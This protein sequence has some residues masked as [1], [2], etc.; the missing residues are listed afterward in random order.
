MWRCVRLTALR[1]LVQLRVFRF[2]SQPLIKYISTKLFAN[3]SPPKRFVL[4]F[5]F[6]EQRLC[7][8][9][10]YKTV[11]IITFNKQWIVFIRAPCDQLLVMTDRFCSEHVS[12]AVEPCINPAVG[13]IAASRSNELQKLTSH[14]EKLNITWVNKRVVLELH[15]TAGKCSAETIMYRNP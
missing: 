2:W 13:F 9:W 10:L 12:G 1:V 5:E 15:I 4:E 6:V 11:S 3:C 8:F 14:S 7:M